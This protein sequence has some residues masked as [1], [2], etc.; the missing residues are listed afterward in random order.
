MAQLQ[1]ELVLAELEGLLLWLQEPYPPL[2]PELG[3]AEMEVVHQESFLGP[4][5][6]PEALFP[7][8]KLVLG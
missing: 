2:R 4:F 8:S 6:W 1:V 3:W 5:P 7:Q